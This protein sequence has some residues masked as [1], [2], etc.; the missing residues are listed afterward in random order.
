MTAK[1]SSTSSSSS[2]F[3]P[4]FVFFVS[5]VLSL[6]PSHPASTLKSLILPL[7]S[8]EFYDPP[9]YIY[10]LSKWE[11][12]YITGNAYDSVALRPINYRRFNSINISFGITCS[13]SLSL[14]LSPPALPPLFCLSRIGLLPDFR[15]SLASLVVDP[16]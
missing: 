16:S 11:R 1:S 2:P 6:P 3:F 15:I 4:R 8:A 12:I 10:A 13:L 9:R 14:S 5:F 7:A